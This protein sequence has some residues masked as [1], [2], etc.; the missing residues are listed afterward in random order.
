MR[1][2]PNETGDVDEGD[3]ELELDYAI[4]EQGVLYERADWSAWR[5]QLALACAEACGCAVFADD[6]PAGVT[7][8][9]RVVG[10]PEDA[11]ALRATYRRMERRVKRAA[12]QACGSKSPEW[13]AR[14]VTA[15]VDGLG[16][17]IDE[18]ADDSLDHMYRAAAGA[19][20]TLVFDPE[21]DPTDRADLA[22]AW[23]AE[24]LGCDQLTVVPESAAPEVVD[25]AAF[26]ARRGR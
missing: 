25:M 7:V 23:M 21:D 2:I 26:A 8:R 1:L 24:H 20:I 5:A 13:R 6:G 17:E 10:T 16:D 4:G 9:L 22:R 12:L 15:H 11:G 18:V 14:W 3:D 19:G